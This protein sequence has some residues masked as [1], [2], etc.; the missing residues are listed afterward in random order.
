MRK[1]FIF[2]VFCFAMYSCSKNIG[3][4]NRNISKEYNEQN[5]ILKNNVELYKSKKKKM[6]PENSKTSVEKNESYAEKISTEQ[7]LGES[8]A[9]KENGLSPETEKSVAPNALLDM[10]IVATMTPI[11]LNK[12]LSNGASIN[13]KNQNGTTV[14]MLYSA[15]ASVECV[16]IL[17]DKGADINAVN[18]NG[19]TALMAACKK[20]SK[21]VINLL[22]Q[23]GA[24]PYAQ[25]YSRKTA[26]DFLENN[27]NLSIEDRVEIYDMIIKQYKNNEKEINH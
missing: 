6:N 16:R 1:V 8:V 24:N 22:L 17:L 13:A 12:M 26:L 14:L 19:G 20:N 27:K 18:S 15:L 21:E 11:K 9:A 7:M 5:V 2:A 23:R 3:G 4:E 25:S 10:K